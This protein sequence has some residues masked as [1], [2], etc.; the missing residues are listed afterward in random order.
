MT[1]TFAEG[2][3]RDRALALNGTLLISG[4][5]IAALVGGILVNWLTWRAAFFINV[6]VGVLI[7]SLTPFVLSESSRPGRMKL[8]VPGAVTVTAGLLAVVYAVLQKNIPAAI[9]GVVL[10]AAFGVIELRSSAPLAPVRILKRPTVKWGNYAGLA[11]LT[12]GVGLVFMTTL[13]LQQVLHFSPLVAG[14]VFGAPGLAALPAGAL[15]G[16]FL[17][18]FGF[19]KVLG[20]GL[21]VQALAPL[22]IV[23]LGSGRAAVAI[24]IPAL[25]VTFF[26]HVINI[27]GYTVTGTAG[28]PNEQ[29][30]LATGLTSMTQQIA[31]SIG[32]PIMG[33]I[34]ATQH[35]ELTGIH[36]AIG[37]N[38]AVLFISA[39]IV[40]FGL[41]LR[42]G[43]RAPAAPVQEEA[44]QEVA[45]PS[46]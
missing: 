20:V 26:A 18:R 39:V 3:M 7:L 19:R 1:T 24:L 5:T 34:A 8:D 38:V 44:A 11:T 31:V 33:A 35:L 12:M 15:S 14:V 28:L 42:G 41:R 46:S 13:Y 27:V 2:T 23:F 21:T 17:G 22:P 43:H 30:G 36:L 32:I 29:Q 25:V 45:V 9:A 10:L 4:F 16:K 40:W 37:V 6:P